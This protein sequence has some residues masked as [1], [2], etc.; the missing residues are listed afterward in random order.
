MTEESLRQNAPHRRASTTQES[1]WSLEA[2]GMNLNA[3]SDQVLFPPF[4]QGGPQKP[5]REPV[6]DTHWARSLAW[7]SADSTYN[8]IWRLSCRKNREQF[9]WATSIL[10]DTK[11]LSPRP[12]FT[13]LSLTE[14]HSLTTKGARTKGQLRSRGRREALI[15]LSSWL[16]DSSLF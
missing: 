7:L 5:H 2:E 11:N 16:R 6:Q 15:I 3:D 10:E 8:Q 14:L 12:D 13:S 4:I 9:W 1:L